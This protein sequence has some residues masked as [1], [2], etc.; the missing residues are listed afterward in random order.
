MTTKKEYSMIISVE[1][2]RSFKI[3]L[4]RFNSKSNQILFEFTSEKIP[5][6]E[7]VIKQYNFS[8]RNKSY[9]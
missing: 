5:N 3:K 4:I 6:I 1:K 8:L 7:D 2:D 9:Y